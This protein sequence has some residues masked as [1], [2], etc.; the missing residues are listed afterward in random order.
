MDN[1]TANAAGQLPG[2]ASSAADQIDAFVAKGFTADE[3]IALIGAH[4]IGK[5]LS[6][7]ALDTTDSKWDNTF[8]SDVSSGKAP[9]TLTSDQNL[10]DSN[11]TTDAWTEYA[12]SE[13]QWEVDFAAA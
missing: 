2:P 13:S 6:G 7:N 3:L 11:Q 8:Y 1:S 4:T 9:A 12:D 10:A 5:N